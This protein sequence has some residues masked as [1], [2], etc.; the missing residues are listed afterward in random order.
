[1]SMNPLRFALFLTLLALVL[2][3]VASAQIRMSQVDE[4]TQEVTI[5][6]FGG[7]QVD[8]STWWM[9]RQPGTYQQ[10]SGLTVTSGDLLLDPGEEVTIIYTFVLFAG[11]GI[12]LYD[13]NSFGNAAAL[14]DYMQYKGVAGFREPLAVTAGLWTAGT[15]ATGDPGPYFYIGDGTENGATFWTNDPPAP[16]SGLPTL[17]AW[18]AGALGLALIGAARLAM[19]RR[20]EADA[21]HSPR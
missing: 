20:S 5:R 3:G 6:N 1:M 17:G 14:Q 2:P 10:L 16:P 13:T 11:T 19:R 4:L 12:G 9:C 21:P 15:F 7:T 18:G 8:V